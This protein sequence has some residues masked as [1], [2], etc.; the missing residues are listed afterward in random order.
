M[1]AEVFISGDR[2]MIIMRIYVEPGDQLLKE[3]NQ[4]VKEKGI[5][6]T[7]LILE[8]L[9]QYLHGGDHGEL[10]QAIAD[11]DKAKA[12]L[13]QNWSEITR[14]RS[15][16]TALKAELDKSRSTYDKVMISNQELQQSADQARGELEGMRKD[17][18][19]FKDTLELK[20]KQITFLEGHVSQLTQTVSQL[21][22]PPG[23]EEIKA[24]SWWQFW[25]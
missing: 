22:L 7:Q 1:I 6:K 18:D 5:G 9:D 21:A 2:Y 24:K 25:K 4:A 12:D 16:I 11:R 17:R 15:E 8:A 10:A 23:Q 20:D 3:V 19:H 13:A 14:V